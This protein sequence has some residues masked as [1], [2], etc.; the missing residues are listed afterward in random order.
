VHLPAHLVPAEFRPPPTSW[1]EYDVV[2]LSDIG[3]NSIQLAPAVFGGPPRGPTGW[4]CCGP[5]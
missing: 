1:A 3:A 5:G 4:A 2:V